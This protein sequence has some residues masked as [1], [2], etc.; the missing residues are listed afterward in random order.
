MLRSLF[1]TD[2]NAIMASN[3]GMQQ[4]KKAY[5]PSLLLSEMYNEVE[6]VHKC[7]PIV[8]L[9]IVGASAGTMDDP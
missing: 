9:T 6:V 5:P 7:A 1:L 2:N 4:K 3:Q 8:S